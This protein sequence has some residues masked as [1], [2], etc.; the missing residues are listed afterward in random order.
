MSVVGRKVLD[1]SGIEGQQMSVIGLRVFEHFWQVQGKL[2]AQE[3]TH[4]N[5]LVYGAIKLSKDVRK[6]K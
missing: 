4:T 6:C 1:T 3:D 2:A 5:A